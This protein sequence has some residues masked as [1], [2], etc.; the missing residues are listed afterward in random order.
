MRVEESK[1]CWEC[2]RRRL[3]C[4]GSQPVCIKC[5]TMGVVCPGYGDKRPLVWMTPGKVVSR[6]WKRKNR[7]HAK[8]ICERAPVAAVTS[9]GLELR[10]DAHEIAEAFEYCEYTLPFTSARLHES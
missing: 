7:A 5:R 2:R 4:D 3:E 6:T 10:T 8:E 1:H 9:P